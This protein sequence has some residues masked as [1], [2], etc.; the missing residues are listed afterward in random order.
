MS[1][2]ETTNKSTTTKLS[3]IKKAVIQIA[4]FFKR[5][6]Q[7][8]VVIASTAIFPIASVSACVRSFYQTHGEGENLFSRIKSALITMTCPIP[9]I[10]PSLFCRFATYFDF[11]HLDISVITFN[12]RMSMDDYIMLSM[13]FVSSLAVS[14]R[15]FLP[16]LL[17]NNSFVK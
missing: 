11:C 12:E 17:S 3:V 4:I 13:P 8:V 2:I 14:L 16:E 9:I 6:V 1:S 15:I 5:T 7:I 10:G